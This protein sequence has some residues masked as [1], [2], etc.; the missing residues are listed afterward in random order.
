M[1]C[2]DGALREIVDRATQHASPLG[3][4][5]RA[6][7]QRLDIDMHVAVAGMADRDQAV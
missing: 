3:H 2:T 7:R 5:S 6:L 1:R 4:A